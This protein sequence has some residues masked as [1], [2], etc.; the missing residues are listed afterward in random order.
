M[1]AQRSKGHLWQEDKLYEPKAGRGA[2]NT[3]VQAAEVEANESEDL[4]T[5]TW[6]LHPN[7]W[8]TTSPHDWSTGTEVVHVIHEVLGWQPTLDIGVQWQSAFGADLADGAVRMGMMRNAKETILMQKRLQGSRCGTAS[9]P[10][11]SAAQQAVLV[12]CATL[13]GGRGEM[14]SMARQRCRLL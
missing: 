10:E 7:G 4:K 11:H 5:K 14:S 12:G 3:P 9:T 1:A 2:L 13:R 6:R 8:H